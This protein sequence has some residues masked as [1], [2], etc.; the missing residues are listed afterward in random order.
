MKQNISLLKTDELGDIVP[1]E[2]INKQG[3]AQ[4]KCKMN[5]MILLLLILIFSEI[6]RIILNLIK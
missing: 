4:W 1:K 5:L 3:S 6:F 2:T